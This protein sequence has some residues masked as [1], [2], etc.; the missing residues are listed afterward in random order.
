MM[1]SDLDVPQ[2]TV[3][4]S[5]VQFDAKVLNPQLNLE[6][7]RTLAVEQ[8]EAGAQLILFPELS[9]TGYVEPLEPGASFSGESGGAGDYALRLYQAAEPEGQAELDL[10][11]VARYRSYVGLLT[12]RRPDVYARYGAG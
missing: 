5:L 2:S 9:N 7:M 6:R 8:A 10:S 1:K 4:A 12:D 3:N 11:A